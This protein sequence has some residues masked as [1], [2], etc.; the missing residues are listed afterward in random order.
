MCIR[1]RETA[2]CSG[3]FGVLLRVAQRVVL[4]VTITHH[5]L[6]ISVQ[7]VDCRHTVSD[8]WR[9]LS[10]VS[11]L[12]VHLLRYLAKRLHI[13]FHVHNVHV[14]TRASRKHEPDRP[15]H[16]LDRRRHCASRPTEASLPVPW[17]WA[18]ST[19]RPP[20]N[21]ACRVLEKTSAWWATF[22]LVYVD[23]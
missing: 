1:D 14:C 4:D 15:A 21:L 18:T 22:E 12:E 16:S 6:V 17:Y 23:I 10:S 11:E 8:G 20:E 2:L 5:A 3:Y 7:R 19:P 9:S 13:S